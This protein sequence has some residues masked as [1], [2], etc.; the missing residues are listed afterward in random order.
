L[1]WIIE[2]LV[3]CWFILAEAF[4]LW[5]TPLEEGYGWEI[6][7]LPEPAQLLRELSSFGKGPRQADKT[8]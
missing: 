7:G 5:S 6:D 2:S 8:Y 1:E 3:D 4:S